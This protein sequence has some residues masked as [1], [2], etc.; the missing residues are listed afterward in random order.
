[1]PPGHPRDRQV[2]VDQELSGLDIGPGDDAGIHHEE[3]LDGEPAPRHLE[4][5]VLR[6]KPAVIAAVD[7]HDRP[8]RLLAGHPA[9]I[10]PAG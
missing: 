7:A 1:M 5:A 3:R 2:I 9:R 4:G 6:E 8:R 10:R